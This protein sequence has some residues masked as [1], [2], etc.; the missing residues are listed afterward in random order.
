MQFLD[1][2]KIIYMLLHRYLNDNTLP[3]ETNVVHEISHANALF[4]LSLGQNNVYPHNETS[5]KYTATRQ[6]KIIKFNLN[7]LMSL[8]VNATNEFSYGNVIFETF[9]PLLLEGYVYLTIL[10]LYTLY[11][12]DQVI[13]GPN[14]VYRGYYND[15]FLRNEDD[16]YFFVGRYNQFAYARDGAVNYDLPLGRI[17]LLSRT[18]NLDNLMRAQS[19][20]NLNTCHYSKDDVTTIVPIVPSSAIV[21]TEMEITFENLLQ[22]GSFIHG[23]CTTLT[24]REL[25]RMINGGFVP[26]DILFRRFTRMDAPATDNVKISC[27]L[28][29]GLLE[30]TTPTHLETSP[31]IPEVIIPKDIRLGIHPER[32]TQR[33]LYL[34]P[35]NTVI[36][37]NKTFGPALLSK[38]LGLGRIKTIDLMIQNDFTD[39]LYKYGIVIK[40]R[41]KILKIDYNQQLIELIR[42]ETECSLHFYVFISEQRAPIDIFDLFKNLVGMIKFEKIRQTELINELMTFCSIHSNLTTTFA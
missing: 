3:R 18:D 34:R 41:N 40:F 23:Q 21:L 22:R 5:L 1:V 6:L 38:N 7:E 10:P 17:F 13:D 36:I 24:S 12:I 26:G 9:L 31:L 8:T 28:D 15:M 32:I 30:F 35:Y 11:S 19:Y 20:I 14:I 16:V 2:E 42:Y 29:R 27:T 33:I 4:I 37:T 25:R 39:F